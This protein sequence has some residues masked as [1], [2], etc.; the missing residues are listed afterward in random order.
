LFLATLGIGCLGASLEITLG[1]A[2]L[3]AQGFGWEWS[4]NARPKDN[5]RFSGAYTLL[6]L[7][8]AAPML[9]GFDPLK[10]TNLA[11]VVTAAS[12]PVTVIP[13][14]VLMNDSMLLGPYTNGWLGNVALALVAV[15]ATVALFAAVPVQILGGS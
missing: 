2:Y 8:A 12:L 4:E 11:M 5:A 3:L 15:L 9:A 10:V 7:L 13:M 1:S 6:L 14:I